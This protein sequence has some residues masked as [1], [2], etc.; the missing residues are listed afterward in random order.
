MLE[1]IVLVCMETKVLHLIHRNHTFTSR[2]LLH[3]LDI[4]LR[5]DTET[6]KINLS[7]GHCS[8][9]INND[10]YEGFLMLLIKSLSANVDP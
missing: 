10:S 5:E 7:G 6:S 8:F 1:L 4:R 9:W 3:L 2:R